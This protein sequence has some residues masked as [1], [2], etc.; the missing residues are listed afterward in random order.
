MNKKQKTKSKE[1]RA[2]NKEQ[3]TGNKEKSLN[4]STGCCIFHKD[5]L[6]N[7]SQFPKAKTQYPT[8]I[9]TILKK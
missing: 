3:R 8:A 1:Q 5:R 6:L 2:K 7:N 4:Y 9:S